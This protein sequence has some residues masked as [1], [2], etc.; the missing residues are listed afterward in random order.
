MIQQTRQ[1]RSSNGEMAWLAALV[2]TMHRVA[3]PELR[4]VPCDAAVLKAAR[5]HLARPSPPY[6]FYGSTFS[7]RN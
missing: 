2:E 3:R 7:F 1:W 6:G 5:A 4:S